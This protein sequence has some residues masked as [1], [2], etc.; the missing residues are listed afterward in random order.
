VDFTLSDDQELLRDTARSLFAKECPTS[1]VRAHA[2]D[3]SVADG[4]DKRLREFA[5]LADAPL[6]DLCLFL[7]EAGAALAPGRFF[8]TTALFAPLLRAI[9]H[10]LLDEV[11]AGDTTGTVAIAGRDGVWAPHGE[12]VKSYVPEGE[13]VDHVAVVHDGGV[14]GPSVMVLTRPEVRALPTVDSS[15]RL[16]ELD[17]HAIDVAAGAVDGPHP[18]PPAAVAAVMERA[19]VAAAAEML[20]TSR[21]MFETTLA[22]AKQREQFDRP[23]GSFQ[24]IKHK[25]AN[26]ALTHER[27]SSAVYYA[28]MAIDAD[29]PDRHR[30]AHVAKAAAG[31]AV[32]LSAKDG[33]QIHGGIGYTWDHDLQLFIRRA[34]ASEHLFG[35][36]GWHHDQLAALLLD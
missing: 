8:S 20:G 16:C 35:D 23:I 17:L 9:E 36:T 10:P 12:P 13:R 14:A 24:A 1:L 25:L 31:E 11:V 29:D 21:W 19:A 15:R 33:I 32:R 5:G 27:A 26:M 18:L 34:Y 4:L 30:A 6:A 28:A 2:D 22:Y 3:P 7:E